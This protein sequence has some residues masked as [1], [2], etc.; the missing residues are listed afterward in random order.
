MKVEVSRAY[1]RTRAALQALGRRAWNRDRAELHGPAALGNRVLRI[2]ILVVRGISSHRLG[3]QAAAL[4]H[5][6]VFSLVPL[7]V[8]ALWILKAFDHLSIKPAAMPVA[9]AMT[10]GN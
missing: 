7:L 5:Y 1:A 10:R 9:T 8:V 6:T 3:V 2:A 4:T